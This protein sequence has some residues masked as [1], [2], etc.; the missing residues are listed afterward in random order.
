MT[1]VRIRRPKADE[2]GLV[3]AIVQN[4]MDE[5]Y[6]GIWAPPPLPVDEEDWR[7]AW[8]AVINGMIVGMALTDK[9]WLGDLWVLRGS[10]GCGVGQRLLAHAEAEIAKRGHQVFRLR[11]VTSNTLAIE[12]HLRHGWRVAHKFA[13]E[14]LPIR[15]FEMV[16]SKS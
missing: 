2:L 5:I 1:A 7:L 10:R 16:K 8:V 4:V 14:R 6:G 9:E 13:H 3:R 15:I 11:V 12:F